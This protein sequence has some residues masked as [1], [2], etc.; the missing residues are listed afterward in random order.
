MIRSRFRFVRRAGKSRIRGFT[1]VELMVSA[2]ISG[3]VVTA[4]ATLQFVTG[5]TIKEVYEQ[6]RTRSAK[7]RALEQLHYK[8][9][10]GAIGSMDFFQN[11]QR[12]VFLDPNLGGVQS[13]FFFSDRLHS[14]YYDENIGDSTSPIRMAT[15]PINVFFDPGPTGAFVSLRV[16]SHDGD[17]AG[18]VDKDDGNSGVYLR[19]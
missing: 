14:L 16:V 7:T 9:S 5:R 1:L 8:L 13:G 12:L 11:R 10:D 18:D 3:L 2:A 19:N 17:A 15:G 6:S 4:V